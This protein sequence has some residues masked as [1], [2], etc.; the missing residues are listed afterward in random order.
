MV[1]TS[2]H[3]QRLRSVQKDTLNQ[4]QCLDLV[5]LELRRGINT[6][7]RH[8]GLQPA[9][10][11]SSIEKNTGVNWDIEATQSFRQHCVVL[12]E[13]QA[14][15]R[16]GGIKEERR[17]LRDSSSPTLSLN[18]GS[19]HRPQGKRRLMK[20]AMLSWIWWKKARDC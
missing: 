20:N 13:V 6:E 2:S 5:F 10:S 7:Q 15:F 1:P 11:T 12:L 16:S 8:R 17:G 3:L 18:E 19:A 9:P 14:E 4:S